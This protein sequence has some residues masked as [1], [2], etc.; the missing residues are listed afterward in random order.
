MGWRI[1]GEMDGFSAMILGLMDALRP[2]GG[3]AVRF[4]AILVVGGL[5]MSLTRMVPLQGLDI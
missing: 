3:A 1:E 4:L 5:L 2:A